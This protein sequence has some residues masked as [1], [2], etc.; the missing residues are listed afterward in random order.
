MHNYLLFMYLSEDTDGGWNDFAGEF[1][2]LT[3]CYDEIDTKLEI[4]LPKD[5]WTTYSWHIVD[6][7]TGKI[8][9]SD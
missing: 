7:I 1:E 6:L 5:S 9:E 4:L 8:I 3:S 2:D